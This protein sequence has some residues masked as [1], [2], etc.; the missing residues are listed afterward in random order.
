MGKQ[1][2]VAWWARST[3]VQRVLRAAPQCG[4]SIPAS[5][6]LTI[7][8]SFGNGTNGSVNVPAGNS[9]H[10]ATGQST[11]GTI[12]KIPNGF[13]ARYYTAGGELFY[14]LATVDCDGEI[15][16]KSGDIYDW[17]F[18]LVSGDLL[19]SVVL[20]GRRARVARIL[21]VAESAKRAAAR[22]GIARWRIRRYTGITTVTPIPARTRG[23]SGRQQSGGKHPAVDHHRRQ[24]R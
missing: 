16:G 21:I 7:F 15:T 17:G 3:R 8:Y 6:S 19:S 22:C 18:P 14:A 4:C 9:T 24:Q 1:L 2:L 23:H 11:G 5:T 12:I 13:G 10:W 20:V